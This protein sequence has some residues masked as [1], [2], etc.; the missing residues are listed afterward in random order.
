LLGRADSAFFPLDANIILT[1]SATLQCTKTPGD[2]L[3]KFTQQPKEFEQSVAERAFALVQQFDPPTFEVFRLYCVEELSAERIARELDCSKLTILRRL[4]QIRVKT[5]L[6]PK[7][8]RRVSAHI[9]KLE[10]QIS[11]SKA[12][13]IQRKRLIDEDA[14]LAE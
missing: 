9:G 7:E 8:L 3:A 14:D 4:N 2:L 11:D 13:N 12:S 6:P 1:H 5:G 10:N